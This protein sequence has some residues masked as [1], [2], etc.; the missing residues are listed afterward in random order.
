MIQD[1]QRQVLEL[2]QYPR[3]RE[4]Q[5]EEE[6]ETS[7][8]VA[9]GGS[10]KLRWRDGGKAPSEMWGKV[11]A[12][13]GS[14][15]YFQ[16]ARFNSVF[17][18]NS[19]NNKWSELSECRNCDF[20]LA[21]I[22]SFLTAIGGRTPKYEIT[23]SLLSLTDSKWTERFPPMPTKRRLTAAVC[24]GES[25]VVAGGL[26]EGDKYLSTVEVMDTETLQWSTASNLP[27]SLSWATAKLCGNQVY[28][29][30]DFDQRDECSKS[31]FTCSLATLL[32]SCK[33][34]SIGARLKTLS[35]VSRPKVWNQLADTPV[36]L[37][38][39]ASLQGR[40]LVVGGKDSD[41]KETTAI[42]MHNTTTNSWEVISHMATPRY[43]CSVAVLPHN[44]LM[45][46][47]GFTDYE[48]TDFVE[49]ASIV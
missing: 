10:I 38:T 28:M 41:D 23:N 40:L 45:V 47:G 3:L 34:Q 27:C 48:V 21:M 22:S 5:R 18:Y 36:T 42:H 26:G 4:V 25:L 8:A 19:A 37:S 44:E 9:S 20:S 39:C 17:A 6:G 30:G 2:Q 14:V 12:V 33:P 16:P 7:G 49:I 43:R 29:L 32:Q 13:D 11:S 1:M 35:L 24:S 31:V 46:V 15:A